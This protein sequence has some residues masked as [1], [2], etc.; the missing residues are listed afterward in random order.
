MRNVT[1]GFWQ[2][3]HY[4]TGIRQA[5]GMGKLV[6]ART[7]LVEWRDAQRSLVG[8]RDR[9]AGQRRGKKMRFARY[10]GRFSLAS[11]FPAAQ[12][13]LEGDPRAG[14]RFLFRCRG[15]EP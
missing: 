12:R 3:A 2:S 4:Y 5:L 10:S 11:F 9:P 7:R 15:E 8:H 14:E 1:M 6:L 13:S